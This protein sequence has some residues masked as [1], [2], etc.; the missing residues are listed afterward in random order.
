MAYQFDP[1]FAKSINS[2]DA[3]HGISRSEQLHQWSI[4]RQ[5]LNAALTQSA[6]NAGCLPPATVTSGRNDGKSKYNRKP[7]QNALSIDSLDYFHLALPRVSAPSSSGDLCKSVTSSRTSS[8]KSHALHHHP[9]SWQR[10]IAR[11]QPTEPSKHRVSSSSFSSASSSS[12]HRQL[13]A[14]HPHHHHYRLPAA[15]Q[16]ARPRQHHLQNYHHYQPKQHTLSVRPMQPQ[17]S[18]V[19]LNSRSK[20]TAQFHLFPTHSNDSNSELKSHA[21]ESAADLAHFHAIHS[22]RQPQSLTLAKAHTISAAINDPRSKADSEANAEEFGDEAARSDIKLLE[23]KANQIAN[24]I[25]SHFDC[26]LRLEKSCLGNNRTPIP[27]RL[28]RSMLDLGSSDLR[29]HSKPQRA[30]SVDE[31]RSRTVDETSL[32]VGTLRSDSTAR[33]SETISSDFN[34]ELI[35]RSS[36]K[37]HGSV[38]SEEEQDGSAGPLLSSNQSFD[39]CGSRSRLDSVSC[40]TSAGDR[41]RVKQ[42]KTQLLIRSLYFEYDCTSNPGLLCGGARQKVRVLDHISFELLAGQMVLL[43]ATNGSYFCLLLFHLCVM[44]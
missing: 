28:G 34:V 18:D 27:S 4:Y 16:S 39:K 21:K 25:K 12:N 14:N 19:H 44:R 33:A 7:T 22:A 10:P 37:R 36:V 42:F 13:L 38:F 9:A 31:L 2:S 29:L 20:T 11:A 5:Q 43:M 1:T 6:L 40:V 30:L 35:E 24:Q 26:K 8:S 32:P 41:A 3:E 17:S 23:T 15:Q